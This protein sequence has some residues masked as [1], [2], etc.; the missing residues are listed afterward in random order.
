MLRNI[1]V[2]TIAAA[3]AALV[4]AS[5]AC[6]Q[7]STVRIETRPFYGAAVTREAGVRVFRP[8][9]P[10]S[11]FIVNPQGRTPLYLGLENNHS[12]SH[13]YNYDSASKAQDHSIAAPGAAVYGVGEPRR[14]GPKGHHVHVK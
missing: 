13:N 7:S 3:A 9:P 10:T 14:H 1:R 8:L 2:A 6:G 4:P 5:A 11:T 12:V